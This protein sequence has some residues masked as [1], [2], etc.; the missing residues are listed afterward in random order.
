MAPGTP[1]ESSTPEGKDAPPVATPSPP[2]EEHPPTPEPR[3]DQLSALEIRALMRE[4]E[5]LVGSFLDKAYQP[6][7]DELLLRLRQPGVGRR[8]L[9]T[10][11]GALVFL[12]NAPPANPTHPSAFAMAI[13]RHAS[14]GRIYKVEQAGFDRVVTLYVQKRDGDHRIVLE[15]FGDG[16][17][18]IVRPD[19]RI[20]LPLVHEAWKSRV[21]RP[22][23]Q[24][25]PPPPRDDPLSFDEATFLAKLDEGNRDLVRALARE[26][27]LGGP[28]AEEVV[29]RSGYDKKTP[30]QETDEATRRA[31]FAA[32]VQLKQEIQDAPPKG[33]LLYE[34]ERPVECAPHRSVLMEAEAKSNPE[35]YRIVETETFS[36]ALD[37][38]HLE[39]RRTE[40]AKQ[41][42]ER[43]DVAKGKLDT[44][45]EAQ[46]AAIE[47]FTQQEIERKLHGDLLWA[48]YQL[49]ERIL[50][51]I[52][53]A[54]KEHDWKTIT[55]RIE[56][57]RQ[58]GHE[59]AR[60]IK[61][62][63]PKTGKMVLRLPDPEG[64][65]HDVPMDI[66]KSVTENAQAAYDASK[67]GRSKLAGAKRALA[68]TK[69]RLEKA[70][71]DAAVAAE[72]A[73][74]VAGRSK[75]LIGPERH[76]WF[77]GYRWMYT[78]T[79]ELAMGGKDAA[80]NDKLVKKHLADNDRY[81]HA[82]MHGAP[83]VVVKPRSDG[84]APNEEA[85]EQAGRFAVVYSR[86]FMQAGSADAYWTTPPQV[87]KTPEPGEYLARGAFI[88]RG[89]RTWMRKLPL[90]LAI[91]R[92]WLDK[93]G[94]PATAPENPD[95]PGDLRPKLMGGPPPA[96]AAHADRYVVLQAGNTDRRR[97]TKG[98]AQAFDAHPD[99]IERLLPP[100]K[101]RLVEAKGM[102]VGE[103]T[104]PGATE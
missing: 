11:R 23:A 52:L 49:V 36:A 67:A 85:L 92:V 8:D 96:V 18:L 61:T 88:V 6:T 60:H 93:E 7:R 70:A 71:E 47:K 57:G 51:S 58:A 43:A 59:D 2:A 55:Q 100:G 53:S 9:Y 66:T 32:W 34:D 27:G 84:Q 65:E 22:G 94:R 17:C 38:L 4:L 80:S 29:A 79:G 73:R 10:R 86:A 50:D 54:R 103:D 48:H 14:G 62:L 28:V 39:G 81:V 35:R 5:P 75:A 77:E 87:S 31:L 46:E 20:L 101:L 91:G 42:S 82:D 95:E 69:K 3:R 12:T 98:L 89:K 102:H 78:S 40:Q 19:G 33:W 76:Y 99:P 15:L 64:E 24:Y 90:E 37:K 97:V 13:R 1:Q 30:I 104:F 45:R 44:Q 26:V 56:K 74:E 83:S 72:D 21:L 63:E 16:N 25:E 41:E 68:E